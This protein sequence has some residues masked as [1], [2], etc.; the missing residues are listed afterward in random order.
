MRRVPFIDVLK[1]V[2]RMDG[3]DP[4]SGNFSPEYVAGLTEFLNQAVKDGWEW[5]WWPELMRAELRAYRATWRADGVYAEGAEV[6]H[7][8]THWYYEAQVA[9]PTTEPGSAGGEWVPKILEKRYVALD[10]EG[11]REIGEVEG[12]YARNPYH[13][14]HPGRLAHSI[15]PDG[16]VPSHLAG[17]RVWVHFRLRPNVWTVQEWDETQAYAKGAVRLRMDTGD[18]WRALKETTA[19]AEPEA[20]P[21]EWERMEFPAILENYVKARMYAHVLR[22]DGQFDKAL[23]QDEKAEDRLCEA[24]DR[25]EPMQGRSFRA[26]ARVRV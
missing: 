8:A 12:I 1:A 14:T 19:G 15:G 10:Q 2:A 18:C 22:E 17:P 24:R 3:V 9:N 23:I 6:W 20:T 11:E 16:I 13:A 5:T 25:A 7:P 21:E 26:T 4:D